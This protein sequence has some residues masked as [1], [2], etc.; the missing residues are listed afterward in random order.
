MANMCINF[1][2]IT[3]D[4]LTKIR[5]ELKKANESNQSWLP[6][7]LE[8]RDSMRWLHDIYIVNDYDDLIEIQCETKWAPPTE[9]LEAIGKLFSVNI[10]NLYEELGS[11][12]YGFSK[13]S[14]ETMETTDTWLDEE[15]L[16]RVVFDEETGVYLFDGEFCESRDEAYEQILQEKLKLQNT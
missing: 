8:G 15:E 9:E 16:D 1:L 4:D 10:A 12:V 14:V 13:F 2:T 7:A 6:E 11:A 5:E 3:G